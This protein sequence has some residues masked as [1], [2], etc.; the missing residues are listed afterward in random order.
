MLLRVG[1]RVKAS[2]TSTKVPVACRVRSSTRYHPRQPV[3][4]QRA[5]ISTSTKTC[6]TT[7]FEE[8]PE[9][10]V[11]PL[12][13]GTTTT[14]RLFLA[15]CF[16][17]RHFYVASSYASFSTSARCDRMLFTLQVSNLSIVSHLLQIKPSWNANNARLSSQICSRPRWSPS[18]W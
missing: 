16:W 2:R 3:C 5:L 10:L 8:V 6:S 13:S 12:T 7:E 1:N 14:T 9:S 15:T 11:T 18:P 4:V 17:I